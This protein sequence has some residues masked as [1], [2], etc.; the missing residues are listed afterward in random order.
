MLIKKFLNMWD[1]LQ[2]ILKDKITP[3]QLLLLYSLEEKISVPQIHST[4]ELE[5]LIEEGYVTQLAAMTAI[6]REGRRIMRKYNNYFIKAKKKTDIQLMGKDF[7]DKLKEYREIFPAGKLPSGKPA[8]V[9]IRTLESSFRWF[10][11]MFEPT[12]DEII[13]ATK[14]YVNEYEAKDYMYMKTSQYFI[15]KTDKNKVK[16]S[17][18]MDYIDMVRD[19]VIDQPNHFKDKVV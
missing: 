15:S 4:L 10:F 11:D 6:T 7:L 3:N 8:R 17:D 5:G 16:T 18:L 9:N 1:L 19:G 14:M 12:W 2:K 13:K